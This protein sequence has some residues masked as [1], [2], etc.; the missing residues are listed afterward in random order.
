[1]DSHRT[2]LKSSYNVVGIHSKQNARR[3]DPNHLT[4]IM[5]EWDG[6]VMAYKRPHDETFYGV[7]LIGWGLTTTGKIEGLVPWRNKVRFCETLA[8]DECEFT[9]YLHPKT[10]NLRSYAPA[11]VCSFLFTGVQAGIDSALHYEIPDLTATYAMFIDGANGIELIPVAKWILRKDG[12]VTALAEASQTRAC[13]LVDECN[14]FCYYV[15]KAIANKIR[16]GDI[17]TL[18]ALTRMVADINFNH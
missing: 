9:G 4:K 8:L 18:G 12:T 16:A 17:E 11:D 7:P 6:H 2:H 1:M 5:L 10:D 14:E 3:L 15:S 13:T